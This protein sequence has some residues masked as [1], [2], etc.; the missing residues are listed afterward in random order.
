[1]R[2]IVVS[3]LGEVTLTGDSLT[4]NISRY[5]LKFTREGGLGTPMRMDKFP[6]ARTDGETHG[7][8]PQ[9]SSPAPQG[10]RWSTKR[11]SPRPLSSLLLFTNRRATRPPSHSP[12][13]RRG[14]SREETKAA[15]SRQRGIECQP[16]R[17]KPGVRCGARNCFLGHGVTP[18]R[19]A[20]PVLP[21]PSQYPKDA[22]P[23][24]APH[25]S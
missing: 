14:K 10:E 11:P 16:P 23:A 25:S 19:R 22:Q 17:V 15:L 9:V 1:V 20:V 6:N 7:G 13:V 12:A 8:N 18:L 21:S 3:Q 4:A 24:S 5:D 2:L